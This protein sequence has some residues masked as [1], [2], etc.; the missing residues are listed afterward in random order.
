MIKHGRLFSCGR[1][2]GID[3]GN[4]LINMHSFANFFKLREDVTFNLIICTAKYN[5]VR[6]NLTDTFKTGGL[7]D[8]V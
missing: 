5:N 7:S 8:Q 3:E 6:V 1:M 2:E 4:P